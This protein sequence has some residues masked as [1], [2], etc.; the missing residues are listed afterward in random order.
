MNAPELNSPVI[1][2]ACQTLPIK[3]K[4]K[5]L[6]FSLMGSECVYAGACEDIPPGDLTSTISSDQFM[7]ISLYGATKFA[8]EGLTESYRYE[9]A[10]F[11]IDAAI[12]EPGTFPT[13]MASKRQA[14]AD[15]ARVALYQNVIDAFGASF[16]AENRSAT[17]PNPQ[18]VAD[19]VARV[20][21]QP[22]GARPL[23]MVAATTLQRQAPQALNE[24]ATQAMQSFFEALH[25]PQAIFQQREER[26]R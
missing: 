10:P 16:Y 18:D 24:A 11:G 23:R 9:L 19:A 2:T 22:A 14:A 4:F 3:E 12:I 8:L 1:S 20:I 6:N 15:S 7:Y 26:K 25:I 21:A 17:P 5:R 13:P